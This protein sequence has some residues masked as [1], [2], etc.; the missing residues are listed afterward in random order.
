[1]EILGEVVITTEKYHHD[2][3][4]LNRATVLSIL[5]RLTKVDTK[6][7]WMLVV[8]CMRLLLV[9]TRKN[10]LNGNFCAY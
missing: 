2:F 6:V 5:P 9:V 8:K 7:Q 4:T 10:M 1:M 3:S